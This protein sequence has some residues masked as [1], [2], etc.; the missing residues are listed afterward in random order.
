MRRVL[1]PLSWLYGGAVRAR[2]WRYEHGWGRVHHLGRP[3]ISVGNLT[4]GGTGK[5][6][7]VIAIGEALLARGVGV[8]VLSRGYGGTGERGGA[9][10]SDGRHAAKPDWEESGDEPALIARRLP[11]AAVVVGADRAAAWRRFGAGPARGVVVLD[12]GYQHLAIAR[13]E[14]VALWDATEPM[15]QAVLAPAGRLREPLSALARATAVVITRVEQADPSAVAAVERR[16]RE[17]RADL[18]V[19]RARFEPQGLIDV[20]TGR[21][22][23]I[24]TVAGA[25][26]LAAAGVGRFESFTRLIAQAGAQVLEAVR[27][28]DHH[29]YRR[30]DLDRLAARAEALGADM[31]LTTE[32]DAVKLERLA[33]PDQRLWAMR[34]SVRI[35]PQAA[36]DAMLDRLAARAGDR[37]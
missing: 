20:I 30:A 23:T 4:M 13:D 29:P 25:R 1:T 10:I 36:W 15:D 27:F 37:S 16:V 18:P 7:L 3:V 9:L 2:L 28:P 12:D 5:T 6:P 17:Q 35:E 32:K 21:D 14:N 11:G 24:S 33:T 26:V 8:T 31:I 19:F 34:I 22:E